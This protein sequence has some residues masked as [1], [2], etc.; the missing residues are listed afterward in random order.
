MY[1]IEFGV[2]GA[3]ELHVLHQ[4][5]ALALVGRDDADLVRLRSGLQQ[6]GGDLLHIRCLGPEHELHNHY[7][8]SPVVPC[9]ACR[10]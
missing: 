6:P 10:V 8:L 5:G 7:Q 3:T 2:Q 4:V 9:V 1:L